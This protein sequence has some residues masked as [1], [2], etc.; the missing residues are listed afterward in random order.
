MFFIKINSKL[1]QNTMQEIALNVAVL[2]DRCGKS[3]LVGNLFVKLTGQP[4]PKEVHPSDKRKY[5]NLVA[6]FR[7][8]RTYPTIKG[9]FKNITLKTPSKIINLT[10]IDIPSARKKQKNAY[11]GISQADIGILVI[12]S[13]DGEFELGMDEITHEHALVAKV[14]GIKH[15][16][17]CINKL[18]RITEK[19]QQQVKFNEIKSTVITKLTEN[20]GFL[21]K[22]LTFLPISSY[23]GDNL[24]SKSENFTW[25]NGKTLYEEICNEKYLKLVKDEKLKNIHL[26]LRIPIYD[27]IK[28][29]DGPLIVIGRVFSGQLE[30]SHQ[31]LI[32]CSP[33]IEQLCGNLIQI[34]S[35]QKNC[36]PIDKA[37]PGDFISFSIDGLSQNLIQRGF[38]FHNPFEPFLFVKSFTAR[39]IILEDIYFK[40]GYIPTIYCHTSTAQCKVFEIKSI[41]NKSGIV[42]EEFPSK[43]KNRD[44][45]DVVFVPTSNFCCETYL[46]FSRLGRIVIKDSGK[47][48]AIGLI[49]SVERNVRACGS[50]S[51]TKGVHNP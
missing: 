5:A 42:I 26:P 15:L 49:T 38:I 8:E 47:I 27:I 23:Y 44:R 29:P 37:S 9:T 14:F 25:W 16:I 20:P 28:I 43:L 31:N 45:G 22:N 50:G 12:S 40:K 6:S 41:L 4:E 30:S 18:E 35:I 39:I 7:K 2:G 48:I 24:I 11:R 17:I 46:E 32:Q 51:L 36:A 21:R 1:S 13:T 19:R 10:L 34:V 33:P 3:T